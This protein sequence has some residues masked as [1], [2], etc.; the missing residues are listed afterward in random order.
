[1]N[2][3]VPSQIK[4]T[5]D[6]IYQRLRTQINR[7][8]SATASNTHTFFVFGASVCLNYFDKNL[9]FFLILLG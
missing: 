4:E 5:V 1:M 9:F 3:N 7:I 2:T 6:Y 8:G